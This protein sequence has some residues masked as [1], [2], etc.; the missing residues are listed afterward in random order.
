LDIRRCEK[1]AR[2]QSQEMTGFGSILAALISPVQP[3]LASPS[4]QCI[5]GMKMRIFAMSI[6]RTSKGKKQHWILSPDA[7]GS[8]GAG[9]SKSYL[10]LR[11]C[12]SVIKA[13]LRLGPREHLQPFYPQSLAFHSEYYKVHRHYTAPLANAC[14]GLQADKQLEVRTLLTPCWV[15]STCTCHPSSAKVPSK[16]SDAFNPKFLG[17]GTT[18]RS[19]C[20]RRPTSCATTASLQHRRL[21]V[22]DPASVL[23]GSWTLSISQRSDST[24]MILSSPRNLTSHV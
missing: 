8:L 22:A 13:G 16:P 3:S 23:N 20:G 17:A 1:V 18:R 10:L 6:W 2:K 15:F 19:S 21:H 14:R 12:P 9:P 5:G 24:P 7:N 4:T 11:M